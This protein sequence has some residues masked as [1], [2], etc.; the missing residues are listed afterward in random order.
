[1]QDDER[2]YYGRQYWFKHQV[3][4]L[5]YTDIVTRARTDL[6]ERCLHWLQAVL[7]YKLPPAQVLEL[8][9]AH[10]GFVAL[11][12]AAGFA[13]RGL[14]LSPSI[15][16]FAKETFDVPMLLGPIETQEIHNG[17]LDV[18]ALMDVIEHLPDPVGT[19][20]HCL[21]LLKPDGVLIIQAPKYQIKK[22]YAELEAGKDRFLEHLKPSE[23]LYLF[24]E[25]SIRQLFYKLEAAHLAFEPAI[26]AHYDMFLVV[27]RAP[28]V[29]FSPQK[30]QQTL[31]LTPQGRLLQATL[32]LDNQ[33]RDL[34][35][36]YAESEH[37]RAARL[38]NMQTLEK[39]LEK[40]KND[41]TQCFG[42][43]KTQSQKNTRLRALF[44][45]F[46]NSLPH[47]L[48]R[49]FD[50]RSLTESQQPTT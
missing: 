27:S 24:S 50:Q 48:L 31:N 46:N 40:S 43:I 13:A 28:L 22:T 9:S 29:C 39:A 2:D 38:A 35:V 32:D 45:H 41:R 42:V 17:C 26:F 25:T 47:R 44:K 14:E 10:G 20:R 33:L 7:K 15:V 49:R 6:P 34:K 8:G 21:K 5:G 23:H 11:L 1:M 36:R 16:Q 12:R 18:I 19:M 3:D 37:D 30:I 4:D